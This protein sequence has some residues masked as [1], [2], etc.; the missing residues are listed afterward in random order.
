METCWFGDSWLSTFLLQGTWFFS[1]YVRQCASL[2]NSF[3]RVFQRFQSY[4]G[5]WLEE[6]EV[7]VLFLLSMARIAWFKCVKGASRGLFIR[8]RCLMVCCL[9]GYGLLFVFLL[10][11][12]FPFDPGEGFSCLKSKVALSCSFFDS[13]CSVSA[14]GS[15]R[16]LHLCIQSYSIDIRL[17]R[18]VEIVSTCDVLGGF[19]FSCNIIR[20]GD[21]LILFEGWASFL[22]CFFR[23]LSGHL[24]T[25]CWVIS[26]LHMC[27]LMGF[28]RLTCAWWVFQGPIFFIFDLISK[29]CL[30]RFSCFLL[31]GG[32]F[33]SCLFLFLF[34]E[35]RSNGMHLHGLQC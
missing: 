12:S 25:C 32:V 6:L 34:L 4:S 30:V 21:F 31:L 5:A 8:G 16:I 23:R 24:C 2:R 10:P 1:I 3:V 22:F 35:I 20:K 26:R 13:C 19:L 29:A 17:M 7:V 33:S 18:L 28:S 9:L 14:W 27:W 15:D 11:I